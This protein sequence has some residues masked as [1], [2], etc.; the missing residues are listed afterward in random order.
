MTKT[1]S[2]QWAQRDDVAFITFRVCDCKD[3]AV[4]FQAQSVN[5]TGTASK[6]EYAVTVEL[7]DEIDPEKST[8]V[9]EGRGVFC[10][11]TKKTQ[12]FWPRLL[13]EKRKQHWLSVDFQRWR[14][15]DDS[16]NDEAGPAAGEEPDFMKMMNQ[17]G[18]GDG[19]MP[20][21]DGIGDD[22]SDDVDSDD[23]DIPTLENNAG[24][25]ATAATTE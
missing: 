22:D 18:G 17:M 16:S 12:C 21:M 11:L 3:A 4:E 7:F 25:T 15:E 2:A 14:D 5:F 23:E 9:K 20:S 1:P 19:G 6:Q 10:T 8:W 13:K 24:D